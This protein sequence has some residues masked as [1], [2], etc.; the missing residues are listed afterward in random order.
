[1]PVIFT[2]KELSFSEIR[3]RVVYMCRWLFRSRIFSAIDKGNDDEVIRLA[4]KDRLTKSK[5]VYGESPLVA[6][7]AKRNSQLACKLIELGGSYDGDESLILATMHGDYEVVSALLDN[8]KNPDDRSGSP[9]YHEGCTALMWAT[10]R[11]HFS[12]MEAL[13]EAGA[14]VN[15]VSEKN[16]T[17]AIYTRKGDEKDLIA[18][19]ILCKNGANI[20]IRD[21]R[22]RNLLEEA[23]DR[24]RFSGKFEMLKILKQYNSGIVDSNA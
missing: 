11:H 9:E 21:W 10:N 4:T 8:S 23:V 18:L 7:I 14:D 22:G 20:L 2:F 6:V 3:E 19:D 17:A 16:D 13:L 1:M 24:Q 12:I 5:G 15:A